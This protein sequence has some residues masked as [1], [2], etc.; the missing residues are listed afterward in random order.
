M[1][2]IIANKFFQEIRKN[3]STERS[4]LGRW[5]LQ[6]NTEIKA[7]LANMD[8]CGDALCGSPEEYKKS[9]ESIIESSKI[10]NN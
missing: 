1:R 3:F 5:N 2:I 6:D 8:C 7:A 9:V 4:L 10:N